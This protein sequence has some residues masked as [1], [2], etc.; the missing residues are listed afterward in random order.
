MPGEQVSSAKSQRE[1]CRVTKLVLSGSALAQVGF[2]GL[3]KYRPTVHIQL[4][5]S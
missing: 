3:E 5:L 4:V 2:A 1:Q